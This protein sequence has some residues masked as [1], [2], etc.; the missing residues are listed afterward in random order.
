MYFKSFNDDTIS[1]S[2]ALIESVFSFIALRL[3]CGSQKK[4]IK[5]EQ[6]ADLFNI[7]TIVLNLWEVYQ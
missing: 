5:K 7:K 3:L 2:F 6:R 4:R 1:I